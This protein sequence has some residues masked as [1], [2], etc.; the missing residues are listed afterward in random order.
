MESAG[1]AIQRIYGWKKGAKWKFVVSETLI[2]ERSSHIDLGPDKCTI[3]LLYRV[4][5]LYHQVIQ[6]SFI[7]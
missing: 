7:L 3:I 2:E 5:V 4:L 1:D 6:S